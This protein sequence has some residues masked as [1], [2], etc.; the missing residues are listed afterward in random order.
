MLLVWVDEFRCDEKVWV[1]GC[2]GK[3]LGLEFEL[4]ECVVAIGF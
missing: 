4:D 2:V 3:A 1:S